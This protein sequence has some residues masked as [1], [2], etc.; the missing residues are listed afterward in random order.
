M[1]MFEQIERIERELQQLY[2][3]LEHNGD[4]EE[5]E[6]IQKEIQGKNLQISRLMPCE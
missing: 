6:L 1:T 4:S 3:L 2:G 5:R